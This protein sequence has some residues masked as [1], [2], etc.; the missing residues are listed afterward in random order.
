MSVKF[1]HTAKAGKFAWEL[2]VTVRH[3]HSGLHSAHRERPR[4]FPKKL[5]LDGSD[6]KRQTL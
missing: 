6:W 3:L 1:K 4:A 2:V 5:N